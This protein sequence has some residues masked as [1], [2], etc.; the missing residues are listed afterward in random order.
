M[1]LI[2]HLCGLQ[3]FYISR[4]SPSRA[5]DLY[6]ASEW[7][8]YGAAASTSLWLI[9]MGRKGSTDLFVPSIAMLGGGLLVFRFRNP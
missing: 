2:K 3:R 7:P 9:Q 6:P 1:K 4:D 5:R 8:K